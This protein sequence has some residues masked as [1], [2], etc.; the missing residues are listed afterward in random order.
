MLR[1]S[2]VLMS[3]AMGA[4]GASVTAEPAL[5][6]GSDAGSAVGPSTVIAQFFATEE[7][8]ATATGVQTFDSLQVDL[9][10]AGS[11]TGSCPG[12]LAVAGPCCV[13]PPPRPPPTLT[14]G[15]GQGGVEAEP[16]AGTIALVDTTSGRPIGTYGYVGGVYTVPSA[17]G[18]NALVWQPGDMLTVSATGGSSIGAF[19]VSAPALVPPSPVVPSRLGRSD[20]V[21]TWQPDPNADTLSITIED[22]RGAE[23]YCRVPDAHGSLTIDASV[24]AA[25]TS[26]PGCQGTAVR[27]ATRYGQTPEGRVLFETSGWATFACTLE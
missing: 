17:Y 26:G 4:C 11:S 10:P 3:L 13:F 22:G 5:S 27:D 12:A 8:G 20:A 14:G 23:V 15:G 19:T 24:L 2:L 18:Y 6:S 21:V 7:T 1:V 9:G 25:L 16:N